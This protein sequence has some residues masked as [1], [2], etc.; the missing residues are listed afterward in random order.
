MAITTDTLPD[1]TDALK[2]MLSAVLD[3]RVEWLGNKATL[4]GDKTRLEETVSARD[5]ALLDRERQIAQQFDRIHQLEARLAQMQH[6][7]FG[8]SSEKNPDQSELQFVNEAELL[9]DTSPEAEPQSTP[10]KA[11]TR[12]KRPRKGF[13]DNLPR[14]EVH[15]GLEG[16]DAL[17]GCGKALK[18]ISTEESEQLAVIPQR[19]YVVRHIC[20]KYGCDCGQAPVTANKPKQ[21][22]PGSG[23]HPTLLAQSVVDKYLNGLPLYRQEKIAARLDVELPRDK[24]A[25]AHIKL[26]EHLQPLYNLCLDTLQDHD[27]TGFDGT[28]L[29]V[30]K[31][32]GRKA[33]TKSALWLRRG[34][35]PE[36]PVVLLDYR[37][38]ESGETIESL[39]AGTRGYLVCDAA[40]SFNQ[41]I[42]QHRL[43]ASLCNDH[44]RRKFVEVLQGGKKKRIASEAVQRYRR[45]YR[46][47][48]RTKDFPP[49]RRHQVRQRFAVPL[50]NR[51]MKWARTRQSQGVLDQATRKALAYLVKHEAGLRRYCEDGRL[52]ISN[53]HTEH[54]AKTVAL[55]RKNFLFA[56][57]P[58][59]AKA[60]AMLM[61]VLE[62]ARANG[63]EPHRYLSVVFTALPEATTVED[64]EAL[65]PWRLTPSEARRRFEA[66]PAP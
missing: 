60:C 66:I 8:A 44:A 16:Q 57:T 59:G 32:P 6:H 13:P 40:P 41:A 38:S 58:S 15:H 37:A 12:Q 11:H 23:L 51:L 17:C 61:S 47:E 62:T 35:P 48:D 64:I 24:L 29:Q 33:Q 25:R 65:L 50:W 53:I 20:H 54:I 2:S 3:E 52:P 31:E 9:A 43:T 27:I 42:G 45:L 18:E 36:T 28:R 4:E 19:H 22:L 14:V 26:A 5:Q 46:I 21:I 49:K 10:V 63:H 7:R 34:G 55:V 1:D 56:D 39:L 30:L